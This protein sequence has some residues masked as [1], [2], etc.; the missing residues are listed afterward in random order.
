M[1]HVPE[2]LE[3]PEGLQQSIFKDKVKEGHGW[4]L[5]TSWCRNPLF[6]CCPRRS[7]H[8]AP[9]NLHQ[10]KCCSLFSNFLS[11]YEL[12]SVIPLKVRVLRMGC[13]VCFRLIGNIL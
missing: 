10:E 4:L 1:A 3:L 12:K 13:P 6:Y 11:L 7:G 2:N 5:Q 9:I 8:D